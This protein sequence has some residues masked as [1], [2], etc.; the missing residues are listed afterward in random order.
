MIATHSLSHAGDNVRFIDI[1]SGAVVSGPGVLLVELERIRVQ[2]HQSM[3][4][5]ERFDGIVGY[6]CAWALIERLL[7]VVAYHLDAPGHVVPRWRVHA[8]GGQRCER[9]DQLVVN[10]EMR[11]G[12]PPHLVPIIGL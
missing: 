1:A 9:P 2:A 11:P 3:Q 12:G 10:E 6:C 5:G 8:G 7:T 4:R